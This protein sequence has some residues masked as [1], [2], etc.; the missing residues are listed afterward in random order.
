MGGCN[1]DKSISRR[2]FLKTAAAAAVGGL[3]GCFP[4]KEREIEQATAGN[5]LR[6]GGAI[7]LEDTLLPPLLF[8]MNFYDR[9]GLNPASNPA[10][11]KLILEYLENIRDFL[12]GKMEV[13]K[14]GSEYA[15]FDLPFRLALFASA[16]APREYGGFLKGN[17]RHRTR[18]YSITPEGIAA[19][20]EDDSALTFVDT[21]MN[22]ETGDYL[23]LRGRYSIEG[24]LRSIKG[25]YNIETPSESWMFDS[26]GRRDY[27]LPPLT[28]ILESY[29]KTLI[30]TLDARIAKLQ[31][32]LH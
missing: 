8:K 14:A 12:S 22:N 25:T 23:R 29:R 31:T 24:K 5:L 3:V 16:N 4:G 32:H 30:T 27:P 11:A 13:L 17:P 6:Y 20:P 19:K 18:E 26:S 15:G 9:D 28:E 21:P 10:I 2:T 1:M 7:R